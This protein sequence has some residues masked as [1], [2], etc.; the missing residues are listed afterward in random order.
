MNRV[1][2]V[3]GEGLE[4]GASSGVHGVLCGW[5]P[6]HP[7]QLQINPSPGGDQITFIWVAVLA[8]LCS[9]Q[10]LRFPAGRPRAIGDGERH[11][12]ALSSSARALAVPTCA[13]GMSHS[14]QLLCW[15][16]D[17]KEH[18]IHSCDFSES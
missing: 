12:C 10:G 4:E 16:M 13:G 17:G 2:V 11:F 5:Y 6:P 3:E 1:E 18:F 14:W 8:S 9:T 15:G 7:L